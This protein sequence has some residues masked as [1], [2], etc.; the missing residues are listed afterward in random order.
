MRAGEAALNLARQGARMALATSELAET[1]RLC[2]VSSSMA[3]PGLSCFVQ[4]APWSP[5]EYAGRQSP[6]AANHP[7]GALALG[8]HA[9]RDREVE[10]CL[11]PPGETNEEAEASMKPPSW[12]AG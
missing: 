1:S 4:A 12:P 6:Q 2:V 11:G 10:G 7:P 5:W 8:R 9:A 3:A